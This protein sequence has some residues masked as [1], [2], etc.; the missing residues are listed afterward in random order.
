MALTCEIM[1]KKIDEIFILYEN[2]E[3]Y[4]GTYEKAYFNS[5]KPFQK[6]GVKY[7]FT[8]TMQSCKNVSELENV[9]RKYFNKAYDLDYLDIITGQGTKQLKLIGEL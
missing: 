7:I 3:K 9:A 1:T 4:F 8:P 5:L 6:K 2:S